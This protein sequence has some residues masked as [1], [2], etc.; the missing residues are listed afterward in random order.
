MNEDEAKDEPDDA[1]GMNGVE[2]TTRA[3]NPPPTVRTATFSPERQRAV[4]DTSA[5]GEP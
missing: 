1:A 4:I 2:A 3:P 5:L